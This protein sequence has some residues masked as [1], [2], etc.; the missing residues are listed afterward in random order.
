MGLIAPAL[1]LALPTLTHGNT[2]LLAGLNLEMVLK[3]A[4]RGGFRS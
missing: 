2:P 3:E 4:R 1:I